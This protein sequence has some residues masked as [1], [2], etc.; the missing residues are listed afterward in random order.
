LIKTHHIDSFLA[1]EADPRLYEFKVL[2]EQVHLWPMIRYQLLLTG[3]YA[4]YGIA[5]PYDPF[6]VDYSKTI[7]YI[8]RTLLDRS[9]KAKQ[10]DILYFGSDLTNIRNESGYFNRLSEL[11][12]QEFQAGSAIIEESANF[13]YRRPRT[14]K[15]VYAFDDITVLSRLFSKFNP[16]SRRDLETIE[17]FIVFVRNNA[18]WPQKEESYWTAIKNTLI[19]LCKEFGP[20]YA[21]YSRLLD[22][23][24]PQVVFKECASYGYGNLPLILAC[25]K[26]MI[27]V[28]EY[29]HGLI[30][31]NHPAY[32]YHP[33]LSSQYLRYLPDFYLA[34]G[35]YWKENCRMPINVIAVGNPY[36]TK[37]I[38]ET[39]ISEKKNQLLYA[40]GAVDPEIC[41]QN[42]LSL[43]EKLKGPGIKVIFRPH[44]TEVHRLSTIYTPVVDAGIP[45]DKNNLYQ[46]LTE[47]K[48]VFS[49]FS[50]VLFEALAFGCVPVALRTPGSDMNLNYP[51]IRISSTMEDAIRFIETNPSYTGKAETLWATSWKPNFTSFLFKT[52]NL[53]PSKK[54]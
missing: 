25:K 31:F 45:I 14:F 34:Y 12:A 50:T 15:N 23:T 52:C 44:P 35:D 17:G 36:L 4:R 24:R 43:N 48:F 37:I 51:E 10:F 38:S 41:V 11:F 53:K 30:S 2:K 16:L 20:K 18:S 21:L 32:N 49:D 29:Q 6:K 27:K 9:L 54:Q 1:I 26:R 39:K 40:S 42:V 5:E 13:G 8:W 33:S 3:L 28:A 47:S 46:T 7:S 19:R 22:K